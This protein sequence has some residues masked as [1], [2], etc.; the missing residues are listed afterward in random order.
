MP[1]SMPQYCEWHAAENI[2][3]YLI[4]HSYAKDK[5]NTMKPLI[6]GYL[7][8]STPSTLQ[9]T[10]AKLLKALK[11]PEVRYIKNNWVAKEKFVFRSHTQLLL[12]LGVHSTQQAESMNAVLKKDLNHQIPLLETCKCLIRAVRSF[13][14][15]LLEGE[16][17]SMTLRP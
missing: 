17:T 3:K 4:D 5:I 16:T 11:S 2:R 7:Q 9:I 10:K 1:G 14:V 6:W 13:E 15:Q 8:S 12:N